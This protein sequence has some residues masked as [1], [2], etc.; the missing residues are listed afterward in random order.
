M[1]T[2]LGKEMSKEV[3]ARFSDGE[4]FPKINESVRGLDV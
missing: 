4:I 2:M 1:T 3:T